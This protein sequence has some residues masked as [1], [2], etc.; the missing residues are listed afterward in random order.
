[1]SAR[2]VVSV[3]L[4]TY[5][6]REALEQ[7]YP[8][9]APVVQSIGGEIVIVDDGS[10]DGTSAFAQTLTGAVS[11]TVVD[12]PGQ[13]GLASAVLAGFDHSHGDVIVVMDADG[14]HPPSVIPALVSAVTD[15]EAEM[16]LGS[17]RVAGGTSPGL[18]AGRRI[19]ST[20]ARSLAR[21][22]TGVHDPMT[23]LF[24]VRR[25][26]LD[27]SP[28]APLGYN[29]ALEILVK[30]RPRPI[31]EIPFTFRPRLAGESK[32]GNLVVGHY[33]QHV[34]RLYAFELTSRRRASSTR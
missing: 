5:N 7:L 30:C 12:R 19:V 22:L 28:L 13:R 33:V 4:P 25:S 10:P 6:E 3:I 24:A 2:P 23:G 31:V 29:I 14:S 18:T 8:T 34:A 27:R 17:R 20:V 16:A 1:M 32:L 21:P 26:I 11:C 9:L 15:Q